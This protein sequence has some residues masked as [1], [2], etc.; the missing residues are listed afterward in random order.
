MKISG[1]TGATIEIFDELGAADT[2]EALFEILRAHFQ[3]LGF[4]GLGYIVPSPK[5]PGRVKVEAQGFPKAYMEK[6]LH[7]GLDR[8]DPFPRH[9]ALSGQPLRLTELAQRTAQTEQEAAFIED[10]R[11]H[12][13]TDGFLIPTFGLRQ[14]LGLF[15]LGQVTDSTVLDAVSVFSLQAVAQ[16]AHTRLDLLSVKED[17]TRT[18]LSQREVSILHWIAA[19]KTNSEIAT[20]L[21]IA[22]PTVAT[23][24]KRIF[25]KMEVTDRSAAAAKAVRFGIIGV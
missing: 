3:S 2:K 19:G 7:A 1:E 21:G 17:E 23:Y 10:A 6:Y 20:I 16:A 5:E 9:V 15:G 24:I 4:Q 13:M 18:P 25:Q 8:H 12:G 11:A 22:N 14:Q